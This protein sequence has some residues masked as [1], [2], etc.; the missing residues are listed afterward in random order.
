MGC[1]MAL[2]L[3]SRYPD[4]IAGVVCSNLYYFFPK[5]QAREKAALAATADDDAAAA[6]EEEEADDDANNKALP[7][8]PAAAAA[9]DDDDD[10]QIFDS[11]ILQED[12]SHISEI[13]G[14][15]SGWLSPDLNTRATLDNLQYLVKRRERYCGQGGIGIGIGGGSI[16]IQDGDTFA[17][18]ETCR[19]V[20]CPVLCVNGASAAQFLDAIGMDMSGQF[21][22]AL[23]FFPKTSS[24]ISTSTSSSTS[25][26]ASSL[27]LLPSP[28][29]VVLEPPGSSINMLNENAKEWLDH[30]TAFAEKIESTIY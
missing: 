27:I 29:V 28:Q 18:E 15:R 30:V 20:H 26:S 21:Q 3:A 17:L 1:Y 25:A 23:D 2:S 7:P 5:E 19:N 10:A 22:K 24:S 13:W 12:G 11:W 4:R 6:E 14:K 9:G 8:P 16:S